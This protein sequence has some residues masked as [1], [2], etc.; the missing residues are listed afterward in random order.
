VYG[1]SSFVPAATRGVSTS[2]IYNFHPH[3]EES[4]AQ[5]WGRLKSLMLKCLMRGE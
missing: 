3:D 4:I 2:Y 1:K 5:A